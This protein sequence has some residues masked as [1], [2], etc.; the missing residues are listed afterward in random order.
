L[1]KRITFENEVVNVL[2]WTPEGEVLVSTLNSTGPNAHSIAALNPQTMKRRVFPVADANEAVLDDSGRYLYFTRFG[3][4]MTN[5]NVREYRGGAMAS[6]WR[7]DLKAKAEASSV[8]S[9]ANA[10]TAP[11]VPQRQ[12][13]F[14]SG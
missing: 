8:C 12:T 7:Y 2:G 9:A 6:I 11:D 14:H 13:V 1:P 3:L 10:I 4:Q 5:D